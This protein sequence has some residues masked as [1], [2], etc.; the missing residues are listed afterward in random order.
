MMT[1]TER[2]KAAGRARGK[3]EQRDDRELLRKA[4]GLMR[5]ALDLTT[6]VS[7]S[8]ADSGR[9]APQSPLETKIREWLKQAEVGT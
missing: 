1:A 9:K 3:R 4:V 2:A 5:Q 7:K 8:F 6:A